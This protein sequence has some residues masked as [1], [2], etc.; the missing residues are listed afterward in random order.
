MA[1]LDMR[2][3][4]ASFEVYPT[5]PGGA[6]V[7]IDAVA[8]Q[9]LED[10]HELVLLLSITQE[11]FDTWCLIELR[12]LPHCD[13]ITNY[14]LA[15]LCSDIDLGPS[16]FPSETYYLSYCWAWALKKISS[17]VDIDYFEFFDYCG[18]AYFSLV[19]RLVNLQDYPGRIGVRIHGP[20]EVIDRRV[21]NPFA[22]HRVFDYA[23]ERAALRL[24]DVILAPGS[25]YYEEEI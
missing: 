10:G 21:R 13:R 6:G 25:K 7:F 8:R 22:N 4:F 9:I 2:F 3:G 11:E 12:R 24:A 16:S 14:R 17:Q 23:L 19:Q 15:D 5:T 20:I 18:P 1:K